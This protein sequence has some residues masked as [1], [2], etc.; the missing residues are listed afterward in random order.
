MENEFFSGDRGRLATDLAEESGEVV[1]LRLAPALEGVVVALRA[2][3]AHAEK[4]L[5]H[6]FQ[7]RRRL[8]HA[9]VPRD[10]R[11]RHDGARGGQDLAHDLVVVRVGQ[12]AVAHP[13]VK[14]EIGRDVGGRI[15]LVFQQGGP[16]VCEVIGV[17][18]A[19]EQGFNGA[20]TL[21]RLLAGKEGLR[22][23]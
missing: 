12:Q 23:L 17:I 8:L 2:L 21:V 19:V 22:F 10:R 5:R 13:G 16:L 15:A 1:I 6:V 18:G 7:L 3:H 4:E 14:G 9:L 20:I 11:V